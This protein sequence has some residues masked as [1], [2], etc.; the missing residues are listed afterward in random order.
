MLDNPETNH[1]NN[2]LQIKWNTYIM[3]GSSVFR[4]KDTRKEA[5]DMEKE[6]KMRDRKS[7][8]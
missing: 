6:Y 4:S 1:Y 2:A 8:V 5:A 7:V 3:E